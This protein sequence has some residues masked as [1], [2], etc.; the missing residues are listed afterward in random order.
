MYLEPHTVLKEQVFRAGPR[1]DHP[2]PGPHGRGGGRLQHP[3]L[4][5]RPGDLDSGSP[6]LPLATETIIV[7]GSI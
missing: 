1:A 7:V 3:G 5:G 6:L 2:E 4:G